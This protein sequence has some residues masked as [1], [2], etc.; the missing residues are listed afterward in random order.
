MIEWTCKAQP[1][2]AVPT[3]CDWPNCGCD[4]AASKVIESLGEKGLMVVPAKPT[5]GMLN[6]A[7]DWSRQKYGKPIGSADAEGCWQAMI[8]AVSR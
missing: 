7:S 1:R 6:A 2:A 4:P 3:D 8:G 5:D